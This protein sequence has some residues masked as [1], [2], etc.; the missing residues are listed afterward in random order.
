MGSRP[1]LFVWKSLIIIAWLGVSAGLIGMSSVWAETGTDFAGTV[2]T[3][4]PAAGK[5]GVKKEGGGTRFTFVVN[6]KTQFS[7]PGLTSLKDVK[8]G[9]MGGWDDPRAPR[10]RT[11]RMCSL[12]GRSR[13]HPSHPFR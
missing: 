3:V 7:G 5:L 1:Q 6:D 11:I 10:A 12:D 9:E 4:D 2:L 13:D 8:K